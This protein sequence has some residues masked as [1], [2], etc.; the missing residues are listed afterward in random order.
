MKS[1]HFKTAYVE[2]ITEISPLFIIEKESFIQRKVSSIGSFSNKNHNK[3]N[4]IYFHLNK[5]SQIPEI[6]LV[7]TLFELC[8]YTHVIVLW[9]E[10]QI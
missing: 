2:H 4:R 8:F 3:K 1:V 6:V 5:P 7:T 10:N 9:L